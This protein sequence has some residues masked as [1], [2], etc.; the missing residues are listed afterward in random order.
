MRH[1]DEEALETYKSYVIEAWELLK[2][3]PAYQK[4]VSE[5]LI[6][7][8]DEDIRTH[9][10]VAHAWEE[11]IRFG[12]F[13][14]SKKS[15]DNWLSG[16]DFSGRPQEKSSQLWLQVVYMF[17]SAPGTSSAGRT[18]FYSEMVCN[19][20]A[21]IKQQKRPLSVL[22]VYSWQSCFR[23]ETL[24]FLQSCIEVLKPMVMEK[25]GLYEDIYSTADEMSAGSSNIK[26]AGKS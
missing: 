1:L 10:K 5:E 18:A 4:V 13:Q 20:I 21:V 2:S 17:N 23:P 6:G 9:V 26:R 3:S 11:A 16:N 14:L 22:P 15:I 24:D 25:E 12:F 19:W 7:K 8:I